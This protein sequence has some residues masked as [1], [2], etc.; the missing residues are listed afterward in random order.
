MYKVK[1]G[2]NLKTIKELSDNSV[3]MCVT[4]PPYYN[5][6]DYLGNDEQIGIE[7]TPEEYIENLVILFREV[8]RTLT[9]DGTLWLNIGDSYAGSGKGRNGDGSANVDDNSKQSTNKG[10]TEGKITK[11]TE[12]GYKPKD[13]MGIPWR[14]AFALQADGWYLRQDIIWYKRNAMPSPVKDRCTTAHEYLF[15]LSKSRN[16]YY[17]WEAIE[18]DA[19]WERW[20]NQ[21]ELKEHAGTASHLGGKTLEE[22]PIRDKKNKR[23]VWDIPTRPYGGAHFATFPP[24]LVEPC[25]LAG[26]PEGGMVLDPFGGS[27]TTAGVSEVFLRDSIMLELNQEYADLVPERIQDIRDYYEKKRPQKIPRTLW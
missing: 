9:D 4:S 27:G 17:D 19:K 23:S 7:N 25:I 20:G 21:T 11:R 8:R 14:V 1:I 12:D 22:L 16:Y 24:E 5:L 26:C 18:E 3:N 15:L 2:N 6:R 13:L 10:S